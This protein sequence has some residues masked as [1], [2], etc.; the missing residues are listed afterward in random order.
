MISCFCMR[1]LI[2]RSCSRSG[3]SRRFEMS[4]RYGSNWL[5]TFFAFLLSSASASCWSEMFSYK[6]LRDSSLS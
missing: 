3:R 4:V 6:S 2:E 5:K 1:S